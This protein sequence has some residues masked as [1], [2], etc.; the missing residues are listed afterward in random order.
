MADSRIELV[1]SSAWADYLV[2]AAGAPGTLPTL[3]RIHASLVV[4]DRR[5]QAALLGT[6]EA[7]GSAW[8]VVAE[9]ADGA[10]FRPAVEARK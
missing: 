8:R 10:I 2:I 1:P 6:L 3:A 7:S 4:V 9:D 5:G